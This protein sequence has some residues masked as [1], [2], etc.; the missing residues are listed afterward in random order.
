[1]RL[2][3]HVCCAPDV[4]VALE[5]LPQTDR[6]S[7]FFDNPNIHPLEEYSRRLSAFYEVICRYGVDSYIG[8][9]DPQNW[10]KVVSGRE[11][12]PEGG[13]R[14]E[15]C[16]GYRL[17]R[18]ARKAVEEGFDTI[19]SVFT[20]S[21]HK[22]AEQINDMGTSIAEKHGLSFFPSNFKKKDGFKRSVQ[23]SRELAL[24]RQNYCGCMYSLP[25]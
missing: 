11:K 15:I 5:R 22:N 18:T 9:Y 13:K 25:K 17:D 21:P 12:D 20:T 16:I 1:M 8:E 3:L 7:L 23:I 24:Y 19:S 4:T 2:L 6:L 14:C 10:M